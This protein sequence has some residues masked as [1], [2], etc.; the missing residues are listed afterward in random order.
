MS[1]FP[2][3][4]SNTSLSPLTL[5]CLTD[6]RQKRLRG[7]ARS[8]LESYLHELDK[9]ATALRDLAIEHQAIR[10][11]VLYDQ[12]ALQAE[13]DKRLSPDGLFNIGFDFDISDIDYDL[14]PWAA[15]WQLAI[16][17]V[18]ASPLE[19]PMATLKQIADWL[20]WQPPVKEGQRL[21]KTLTQ[22]ALW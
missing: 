13:F 8:Q 7:R 10:F 5:E 20:K 3:N 21:K 19:Y 17:A 2:S 6:I 1:L 12:E 18:L 4:A 15:A 9:R 11:F 16:E 14:E 22:V